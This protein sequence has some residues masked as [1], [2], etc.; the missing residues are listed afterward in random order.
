MTNYQGAPMEEQVKKLLEENLAY[1]KEIH[2][3]AKKTKT[4][5]MWGRIMSFISLLFII[6]PIILG[7]IYLPSILNNTLSKIL[8][9]GLN[10]SG[11]EGLL[12]GSNLSPEEL[13]HAIGNQ[14]SVLD[15]YKN[16]LDIYK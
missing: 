9:T 5:I 1:S 8:P 4:Y 6:V 10:P 2:Q 11:V 13:Q 16:I 12:Q 15:S 3:L 7:V 14:G